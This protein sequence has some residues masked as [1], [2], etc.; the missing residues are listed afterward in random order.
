MSQ[1]WAYTTKGKIRSRKNYEHLIL[2][3]IQDKYYNKLKL[4][5]QQKEHT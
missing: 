1:K 2:K 3:F 5:I 4:N